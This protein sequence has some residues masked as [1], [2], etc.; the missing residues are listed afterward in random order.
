MADTFEST[1]A[2]EPQSGK[3]GGVGSWIIGVFLD[4]KGTFEAMAGRLE[5]PHPTD[6]AKTKDMSKWWIPI[7]IAIV[8]TIGI[9]FYTIPNFI[10]PMQE[11][12]VREAVMSRGGTEADVQQAMGMSGAMMMPMA[13]IG[14]IIMTILIVFVAAGVFHLLMKMVGGKG[15]FRHA[16]AVVAWST[17][18]TT[19]GSLIKLPI[20]I[21]KE[22]MIV[23]T[24]PSLFFK[25]LEP[26][27]KLF[28]FLSA[29]DVFTIWWMIVMLVG[30]AVTYRV[31]RGKAAV[32]VAIAWVLLMLI[33]TFTPGGMGAGM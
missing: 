2:Q 17:L 19:L 31:S 29:F 16:R 18:I 30:L 14:V 5:R 4:P 27:D 24:G 28:K 10:A 32:A 1:E 25:N 15:R 8:I 26:S 6:P 11:E 9:T 12:A 23:E 22:S 20:M 7:L 21:A 3:S 13:I 33:T